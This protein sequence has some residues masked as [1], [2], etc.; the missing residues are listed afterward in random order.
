M[1]VV[2]CYRKPYKRICSFFFMNKERVLVTGG[3]GYIGSILTEHL[4]DEDYKVTCLDNLMYG[5]KSLLNYIYI[6]NFDFI[7]GDVR[8]ESLMKEIVPKF[9][10]LL[11]LA[12]IV[13]VPACK[14]N[15]F[16]S[17]SINRDVISMLN[18]IRGVQQKVIFPTTNSGYGTKNVEIYCT[19]DTPLEPISL[20]GKTK[21]EAEKILL[22]SEKP[23]ITLRLATVFGFSPRMRRDLLVN[24]FVYQAITTNCLKIYE[25]DFKRNYIHVRDVWLDDANLSKE[26]LALKIKEYIPSL[27]IYE[28][29]GEDIDK[30]NYIVSNEKIK[31]TGF[32]P[33]YSLDDG[34]KEL[35]KGYEIILKTN[36]FRNA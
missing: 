33:T 20:Y 32:K 15:P 36:R 11:P 2:I 8:N 26:E 35:I 28:G 30:R 19:E 10:V 17:E 34:I 27:S 1:R 31:K 16:D 5:Q 6:P 29:E 24:D 13:G 4:L 14:K 3:A 21:V 9:D 22:E 23:A 12:A 25:K 7:Y 18:E